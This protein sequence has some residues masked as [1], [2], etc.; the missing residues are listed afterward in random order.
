MLVIH[1]MNSVSMAARL[2]VCNTVFLTIIYFS[3]KKAMFEFFGEENREIMAIKDKGQCL[4]HCYEFWPMRKVLSARD[5]I[6]ETIEWRK[7]L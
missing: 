5:G 4:T 1:E 7:V 3:P 6:S 2:K